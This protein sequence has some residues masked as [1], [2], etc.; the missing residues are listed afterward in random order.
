[1]AG[2]AR[3]LGRPEG[4]RGRAVGAALNRGNRRT[5]SAA[6]DA[7][8]LSAGATAADVGFGGG[9][10]L[11][12]LLRRVGAHGHVAGAEISPTM[13][14]AATKRFRREI[15]AGRLTLHGAPMN[16][17]PL[18]AD[19]LDGIVTVNTIYF[20]DDLEN[21]FAELARV[22]KPSGRVVIGIGD[23]EAMARM[24]MTEH[25]F[26]LRA[27]DEVTDNMRRAGLAPGEHERVGK[28]GRVAHV[29]VARPV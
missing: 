26:R 11:G 9:V 14:D 13:I 3:Q 15:A 17:L 29:I 10:G 24:P 1:M 5:V 2:L 21:A 6:I 4:M 7:L 27:V 20:I 16:E 12:L 8:E 23:P 28:G 19:S 22:I 25:G 18:A